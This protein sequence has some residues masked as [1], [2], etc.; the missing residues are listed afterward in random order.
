MSGFTVARQPLGNVGLHNAI[1]AACESGLLQE[2]T[3]V[4]TLGMPTDALE[5]HVKS[6]I[7]ERLEDDHDCLTVF[8]DDDD[9]DGVG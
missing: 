8:V 4:G 5:S 2:K 3:W 9:F 6:D 1:H 7:A